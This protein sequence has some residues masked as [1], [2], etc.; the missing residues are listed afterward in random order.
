MF[1]DIRRIRGLAGLALVVV[2][3]VF[4]IGCSSGAPAAASTQAVGMPPARAQ[5][6]VGD[7]YSAGTRPPAPA[8]GATAGSVAS[9]QVTKYGGTAD[10]RLTGTHPG[11]GG[12]QR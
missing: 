2:V 6:L 1:D 7:P 9:P 3:G 4:A 5:R 11:G 12:P 8:T 10:D